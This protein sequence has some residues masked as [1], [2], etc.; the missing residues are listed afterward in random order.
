MNRIKELRNELGLKQ[1]DL[2]GRIG[3][4]HSNLSKYESEA[5]YPPKEVWIK[6]AQIFGV[7][8]DYL[9]GIS[10]V[11]NSTETYNTTD[12]ITEEDYL[13]KVGN[14]ISMVIYSDMVSEEAAIV[15]KTPVKTLDK[16]CAGKIW[17]SKDFVE[18]VAQKC[19][20][21]TDYLL[22]INSHR[23]L[24]NNYDDRYPFTIPSNVLKRIVSM[25]DE[26]EP[27]LAYWQ[28]YLSVSPVE[29]LLLRY[30]GFIIHL[31]VLKK[32]C[33]RLNVSADYLLGRISEKQDRLMQIT[34]D[35]DDDHLDIIIGDSQRYRLRESVAADTREQ[36]LREAK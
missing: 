26:C 33:D 32:M 24:M 31:E 21:S 9:M 35:L 3:V 10:D 7:S 18:R 6:L 28:N 14:R 19:K 4:S 12:N 17:P 15:L 11:R 2:A 20:V 29:L 5:H 25:M 22:C 8:I 13:R 1:E 34:K 30:Y 27:D 23:R 16:I 36:E